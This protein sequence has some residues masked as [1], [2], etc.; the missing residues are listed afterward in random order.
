MTITANLNFKNKNDQKIV[1]KVFTR[2]I[3]YD[4]VD[5]HSNTI[6]NEKNVSKTLVEQLSEE[7]INFMNYSLKN[8]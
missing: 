5:I 4:V 2:R 8:K 1:N 3:D 6:R 7:I